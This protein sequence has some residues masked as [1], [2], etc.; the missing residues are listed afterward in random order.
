MAV[1]RLAVVPY[2]L[3]NECC[4]SDLRP[5]FSTAF[6]GC[7]RR[8]NSSLVCISSEKAMQFTCAIFIVTNL[9]ERVSMREIEI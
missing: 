7:G 3:P 2:A 8:S 1:F 9:R 4:A 5:G 6:Q